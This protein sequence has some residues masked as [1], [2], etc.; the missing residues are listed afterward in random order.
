[1]LV[2]Y[3]VLAIIVLAILFNWLYIRFYSKKLAGALSNEDFQNTMRK[4]QIIDL[5]GTD[6][7]DQSHILGA[8]SIPYTQLKMS[9]AEMRPDLPVY[10]Y[11][12]GQSICVRAA[13]YL[14]SKKGFKNV[15]WL[16]KGY[17]DWEGKTKSSPKS[18]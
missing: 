11:A 8:R 15:K 1:M 6:A 5:R 12:D 13:R 9:F 3:V 2:L 18:Y 4:A 17:R 16:K 14:V 7:F 10:L